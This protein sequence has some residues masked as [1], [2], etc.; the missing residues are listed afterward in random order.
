MLLRC[1][2]ITVFFAGRGSSTAAL[3]K[4]LL[5]TR[6][7]SLRSLRFPVCSATGGSFPLTQNF[8][9]L[10]FESFVV[11]VSVTPH[12]P[13]VLPPAM[14]PLVLSSVRR[15]CVVSQ[16]RV[17]AL[18]MSQPVSTSLLRTP[19]SRPLVCKQSIWHYYCTAQ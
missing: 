6:H 13:R 10:T 11:S 16:N 3:P 8:S 1:C 15:R 4:S 12:S 17:T 18:A 14:F 2:S 7:I 19:S 9:G 5:R